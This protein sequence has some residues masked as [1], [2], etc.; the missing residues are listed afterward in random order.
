MIPERHAICPLTIN[1]DTLRRMP[2]SRIAHI[3]S[4]ELRVTPNNRTISAWL[5]SIR[6]MAE[7]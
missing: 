4:K 1:D 5:M 6:G 3:Y 7:H 2:L